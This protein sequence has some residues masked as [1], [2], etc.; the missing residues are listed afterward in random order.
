MYQ[1]TADAV[2][3]N[4]MINITPCTFFLTV[5]LKEMLGCSKLCGITVLN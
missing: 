5:T 2:K 1:D 4:R 3:L